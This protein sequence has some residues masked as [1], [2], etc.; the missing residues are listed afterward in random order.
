MSQEYARPFD[1]H[2]AYGTVFGDY[3]FGYEQKGQLYNAAKNPVDATGKPMEIDPK[4][5]AKPKTAPAAKAMA[6][7]IVE[8]EDDDPDPENEMAAIDLEAWAR[9]W[10]AGENEVYH[11]KV[12]QSAVAERYGVTPHQK[13]Q[14]VRLLEEKL[15][16]VLMPPDANPPQPQQ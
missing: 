4:Y 12:I 9:S 3:R 16:I 10:V 13:R 11:W 1:E 7:A 15:G 8:D 14:A 2:A 6:P 5:L